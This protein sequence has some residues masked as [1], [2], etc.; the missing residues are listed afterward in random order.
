MGSGGM[1]LWG[2]GALGVRGYVSQ[3]QE[4]HSDAISVKKNCK[5]QNS[6]DNG[7]WPQY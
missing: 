4:M 7:L 6:I 2:Y 1:G 5:L 3:G